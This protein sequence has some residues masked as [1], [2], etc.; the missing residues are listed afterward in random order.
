MQKCAEGRFFCCRIENCRLLTGEGGRFMCSRKMSEKKR[1]SLRFA[2]SLLALL[3]SV[4]FSMTAFAEELPNKV[5]SGS[6]FGPGATG[7]SEDAEGNWSYYLNGTALRGAWGEIG[8]HWY[9]FNDEEKMATGWQNIGGEEYYLAE[10]TDENHPKGACYMNERTPDGT[11]VDEKGVKV[12]IPAIGDRPNPY[13]YSCVEVSISEQMVYCY[14]N[15]S[16]VWMSPCV[17]G[18]PGSRATTPGAW[19]INSKERNRYL[20]GTNSDGSRYKSWVNYWMP[21]HNGQGLHDA[22]WRS[23]FGGSIYVGSG[24]HGCVNLPRDAAASLY[25]IVW[26][27]MPV[28]VHQ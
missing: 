28:M 17:T 3:L 8:G 19:K 12:P 1:V 23:S 20:Q 16:L 15:N 9:Y 7:W 22:S 27:G 11:D 5:L 6:T 25:N 2:A 18:R 4:L 24:S 10:Q 26:V 13:G 21:F 14:L